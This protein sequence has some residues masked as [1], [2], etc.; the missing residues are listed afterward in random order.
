MAGFV[1]GNSVQTKNFH[2]ES[3]VLTSSIDTDLLKDYARMQILYNNIL[4]QLKPPMLLY[5]S[6]DFDDFISTISGEILTTMTDLNDDDIFFYG[7]TSSTRSYNLLQNYDYDET[8]VP[9]FRSI[10]NSL[11]DVMQQG[12][13]EYYKIKSLEQENTNLLSYKEIL[14][15]RTQLLTYLSDIQT[16]SYL[17]SAEATY[18]NDIDI[19]L[20]YQTYLDRY[21]APSDGVFDSEILASIITELIDS[22]EISEDELIY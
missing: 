21:G 1:N 11:I 4:T 15:D 2:G 9:N 22:G 19:K 18:T 8:L 20:W 5:A 13:S 7:N 14:E 3:L 12:I 6:G 17:F 16:T 10:S